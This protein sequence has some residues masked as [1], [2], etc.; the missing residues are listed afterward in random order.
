MRN[1]LRTA[2]W[3]RTTAETAALPLVPQLI[4]HA[5]AVGNTMCNPRYSKV[6]AEGRMGLCCPWRYTWATSQA[7]LGDTGRGGVAVHKPWLLLVQ[8]LEG[9]CSDYG[10]VA[11]VPSCQGPKAWLRKSDIEKVLSLC[12][13]FLAH[14][15]QNLRTSGIF[16][17]L[18]R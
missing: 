7:Q 13:Q 3:F 18:M 11:T 5:C 12:S 6:G 14:S 10:L 15:S 1:C 9:S 4:H 16:S 8:L 2:T 17:V